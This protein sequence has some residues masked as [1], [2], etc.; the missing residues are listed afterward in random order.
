MKRTTARYTAYFVALMAVMLSMAACTSDGAAPDDVPSTTAPGGMGKVSLRIGVA[1]NGNTTRTS[2]G[3]QDKNANDDEMMNI[4]TV[5]IADDNDNNAVK[6]LACKPAAG[7]EREDDVVVED[8]ELPAGTYNVYSFANMSVA[9]VAELIGLTTA[10]PE[11]AEPLD[12]GAVKDYGDAFTGKVE[13]AKAVVAVNGNNFDPKADDNGFGS[14][15]IPMSNVQT[16]TVSG[17]ETVTKNLI[18]IRM[19]AK[20]ELR[21]TNETGGNVTLKEIAL[22]DITANPAKG[23]TNPVPEGTAANLMLLPNLTAGADDMEAHHGGIQPN[24]NGTPATEV[25]KPTIKEDEKVI[26]NGSG[27]NITFYINESQAPKD[28]HFELTLQF[29]EGE[30]RYA[31]I[32]D[33]NEKTDDESKW[34]YIARNDYRIIPVTLDAYK[35]ELIP[36]DFPPIGV[37]PA[38]VRVLNESENLYE[39]TFHDYGHFHLVPRV[40][41]SDTDV[42]PFSADQ[43]PSSTA[44]T[45][46]GNWDGSWFTASAIG[47]LTEDANPGGFYVK[48]NSSSTV[49]ASENGGIPVFDTQTTWNGFNPFIFGK[50]AKPADADNTKKEDK[51]VYHEFKIKLH[52]ANA[53]G[54]TIYDRYMIYRFNMKLSLSDDRMLST[55]KRRG[56]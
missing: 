21:I 10:S 28:S 44:W 49:D 56:H 24:L 4:W 43:N 36:Y 19:L 29:D 12:G 30:Y 1:G 16:V 3:W 17:G 33:E 45:L 9:K 22:T 47:V 37:L 38:S 2:T 13:A 31:V 52:V 53:D 15:G 25:F 18:V 35:L 40:T 8:L 27:K 7:T 39:M 5:V 41:K 55:A 42:V 51:T 20:M 26:A 14:N 50:I 54:S 48:E 6:V 34:N 32:N 11:V 46:N 23:T